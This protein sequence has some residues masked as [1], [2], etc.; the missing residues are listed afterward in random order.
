MN[1]KLK[2][3]L[4]SAKKWILQQGFACPSCGHPH[5][6]R[7]S[8]KYVV[9][10]LRR[11][12]QCNLLFRAPTTTSEENTAFYQD[13][14]QE[15]F[16]TELPSAEELAQLKK[17]VFAGSP[18]DFSDRLQILQALN[19]M[20]GGRVCD[21]GCSWGYGSWQLRHSGFRVQAFEIS[22]PRAAFALSQLGVDVVS[23]VNEL[24]GPFD[25]FFSSH[26]LEHVPSVQ[27]IIDL[28]FRLL[29]PGGYFLAFTPNGSIAY[30][31]RNRRAWQSTW[32]LKHANHLDVL[33][34]CT[35]FAAQPYYIAS[36]PY[37]HE[38]LRQWT[39]Q[40]IQQVNN[41]D[42]GELMVIAQK[43]R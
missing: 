18:K 7:L 4:I 28:G 40:P 41:L 1:T 25:I 34:Y 37:R 16:T 3:L 11:C 33:F 10:T 32:G 39:Q 17:N 2:Y 43:P 6:V 24:I 8:Q 15:G 27:D 36:S 30:R 23:N 42:G 22:S 20:N 21:F 14:Y 12:S 5:S 38:E 29:R 31:E 26:V 13:Q 19:I 35:T 9:T